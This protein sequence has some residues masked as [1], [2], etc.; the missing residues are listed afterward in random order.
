MGTSVDDR[1]PS[2]PAAFGPNALRPRLGRAAPSPSSWRERLRAL[3]HLPQLLRLVWETEPRYVVGIFLLRIAR[4]AVPLAVL[5]IGKLIVDEVIAAVAGS[6]AGGAG[7]LGAA[8]PSCS[9]S[10]SAIALVGRRR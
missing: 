10:S 6:A 5:W 4:A 9:R 8:W 1:F 3:R 2:A 7:R